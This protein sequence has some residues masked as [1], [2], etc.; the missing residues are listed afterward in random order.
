MTEHEKYSHSKFMSLILRHHPE[1]AG[2]TLDQ[3]GWAD[4]AALLNGM[5]KSGHAITLEQMKEVVAENDKQRFRFSDDYT[6]IRANQGHSVAVDVELTETM[7]LDVLYHGTAARFIQSIKKE[8][9]I[10]KGRLYVHLSGNRET[11]LKVG[12]RHGSPVVLTIDAAE[13]YRNAKYIAENAYAESLKANEEIIK[14]RVSINGEITRMI[15]GLKEYMFP[16]APVSLAPGEL[17]L[18]YASPALLKK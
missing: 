11:A 15:S 4:T 3:N 14:N 2:I 7:P 10:P 17:C 9:L 8:G 6:K 1:A 13:M 18:S 12:Q 16:E 5:N